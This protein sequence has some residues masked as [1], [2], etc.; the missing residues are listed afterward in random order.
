MVKV[1]FGLRQLDEF[2]WEASPEA[3]PSK[4]GGNI[5]LWLEKTK[6]VKSV[7][8]R[9][10]LKGEPQE[11]PPTEIHGWPRDMSSREVVD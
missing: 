3:P 9:L 1:F 7:S 8:Y 2:R 11:M 4:E 6:A 5:T 10:L